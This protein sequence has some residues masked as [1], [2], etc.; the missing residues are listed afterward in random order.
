[1]PSSLVAPNGKRE[2]RPGERDK[3]DVTV[4]VNGDLQSWLFSSVGLE[5]SLW[6]VHRERQGAKTLALTVSPPNPSYY[7]LCYRNAS[8]GILKVAVY[9]ARSGVRR[10]TCNRAHRTRRVCNPRHQRV[11]CTRDR[12]GSTPEMCL[13]TSQ[14]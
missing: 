7:R 8:G 1:M 14:D 12:F 5:S 13:V 10:N 6:Q 11:V 2:G 9:R 4:A 3:R